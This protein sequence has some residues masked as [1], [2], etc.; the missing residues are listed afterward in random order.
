MFKQ[1][2]ENM[3]TLQEK[4]KKREEWNKEVNPRHKNRIQQR[5]I[6]NPNNAGM[7]FSTRKRNTL[8]ENLNDRT[9]NVEN[10]ESVGRQGRETG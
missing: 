10:K 7:K 6:L 1:L 4:K 8:E 9:D 3:N 2:T 5:D